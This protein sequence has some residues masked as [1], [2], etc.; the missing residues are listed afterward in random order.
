MTTHLNSK[1]EYLPSYVINI[2]SY[3]TSLSNMLLILI[4]FNWIT[5]FI[6]IN[7]FLLNRQ[8][9][10]NYTRQ[11]QYVKERLQVWRRNNKLKYVFLMSL[12]LSGP[13]LIE[14]VLFY[15]ATT[16]N[17]LLMF[18]LIYIRYFWLISSIILCESFQGYEYSSIYIQQYQKIKQTIQDWCIT[19]K[20]RREFLYLMVVAIPFLLDQ[21][22]IYLI[23][24]S[25]LIFYPLWSSS[26]FIIRYN[27]LIL[28]VIFDRI[29]VNR[30]SATKFARKYQELKGKTDNY[31]SYKLDGKYTK[32]KRRLSYWYLESRLMRIS[33]LILPLIIE[34]VFLY[35]IPLIKFLIS[36]T[37]LSLMFTIRYGWLLII[38]IISIVLHQQNIFP[39]Y[40]EKFLLITNKIR[41]WM[42]GSNVKAALVWFSIIVGPFI[43]EMCFI[44]FIPAIEL[45][46]FLLWKLCQFLII[47]CWLLPI[48]IMSDVL[49][50]KKIF[51]A[52][53]KK[54]KS[55]MIKLNDWV[56]NSN[57]KGSIVWFIVLII[58]A[59]CEHLNIGSRSIRELFISFLIKLVLFVI[60]YGWLLLILIMSEVLRD[61]KIF[62]AY[63]K[64]YESFMIKL[65]DWVGNSN[66][67]DGIVWFIVLIIPPVCEHLNIGSRS[68]RELF[69]SFLIKLVLFVIRYGWLLLILIMVAVLSD[70]KMLPKYIE[71]IIPIPKRFFDWAD[72]SKLKTV[73]AWF[74]ILAGPFTLEMCII[75]FLPLM[76]LFL[77]FLPKLLL[78]IIRYFWFLLF[79][80]GIEMLEE[81]EKCSNLVAKYK[82]IKEPI[83]RW[84]ESN[85][86]RGGLA[87]VLILLAPF[88]LEMLLFYGL[89]AMFAI[90]S[91]L[92]RKTFF[93]L[94]SIFACYSISRWIYR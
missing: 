94:A 45:L 69:I 83:E 87:I 33:L 35:T 43:L 55:F 18:I 30:I 64:K 62:L 53:S 24:V 39:Q 46:F 54:Y 29:L 37:W 19:H 74:I 58:P 61:K 79:L 26:I 75:W 70:K 32:V 14:L 12:I 78:F 27:W 21:L 38:V 72:E 22:I 48:L 80:I 47:Y 57:F 34:I 84:I 9:L 49:D 91:F 15:F 2:E 73:L 50:E 40:V 8:Y 17:H 67:K 10:L 11:Y 63:S 20:I 28:I 4:R 65:N 51:L 6:I 92:V 68:I 5:L 76:K 71:K 59:V 16:M 31:L 82:T 89:K 85:K 1:L 13:S 81:T 60:R 77:F 90:I 41:H 42:N 52:Y 66:F 93:Y 88:L 44:W 7:E 86:F 25:K 36:F 23:I 3:S 56:G